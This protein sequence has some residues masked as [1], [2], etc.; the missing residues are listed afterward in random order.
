MVLH[1][2]MAAK[3]AKDRV[4]EVR[5]SFAAEI[6]ANVEP[7]ERDAIRDAFALTPRE[8]F[9]GEGPWRILSSGGYTET[10]SDDPTSVYCDSPI[11]IDPRKGI[12]N[13]QPTL[14]VRCMAALRIRRGESITHIGAGTGYYTAIL[15]RLTGAQGVVHAFE[16]DP[17]LAERAARNLSDLEQ[18]RVYGRS[19]SKGPLPDSDVIYV[20]AG[21]TAP[22]REWLRALRGGGRLLFPLTDAEG[23]GGVLMVTRP[24]IAPTDPTETGGETF[25][26]VFVSSV[27]FIGCS[28]ARDEETGNRLSQMFARGEPKNVR[29]LR[30][31]SEPDD[32]CWFAGGDWWLSR[33]AT[34]RA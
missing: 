14:Y 27:V 4:E 33:S 3:D 34:D 16:I 13:G 18:V 12:N 9:L 22:Q 1:W 20:S 25:A 24:M 28:G 29:S 23:Y 7:Q 31:D 19:G 10:P 8:R 17:R 26:A 6:T 2:A 11:A 5:E 32:T 21:A 15:A 30:L